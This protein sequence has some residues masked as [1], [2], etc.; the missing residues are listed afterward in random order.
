[1]TGMQ[2]DNELKVVF[3]AP[4]P[5]ALQRARNNAMNLRREDPGAYVCIVINAEAVAGALDEAHPDADEFTWVC[6]NTL[7][8]INREN[9][10]PLRLLDRAAVLELVRLQQSGW[11]YIRS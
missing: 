8:R 9:R 7:A 6:P 1:M 2:Q 5:E 4:T 10:Q 11:T 3:H